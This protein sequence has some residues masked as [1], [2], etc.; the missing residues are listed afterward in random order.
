[1]LE[2]N[3]LDGFTR[4]VGESQFF[5]VDTILENVFHSFR[6]MHKEE[7]CQPLH[8]RDF[9]ASCVLFQDGK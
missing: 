1:M 5:I 8:T 6:H 7:N 3:F 9:G 4:P 2:L